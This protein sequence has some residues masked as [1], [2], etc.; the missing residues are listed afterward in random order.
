MLL[1]WEHKIPRRVIQQI[2]TSY[3]R[4][5]CWTV[6]SSKIDIGSFLKPGGAATISMGLTNGKCIDRGV[7]PWKM[8]RWSYIVLGGTSNGVS[9]LIVTGYRTG[10][11]SSIPGEK[12]A[13]SQQNTMLL[14]EKRNISPPEAFLTDLKEWIRKYRTPKMEILLSLDANE[15][16]TEQ[17]AITHFATDLGLCNINEEFMLEATHPNIANVSRSTTI[18]FC[19]SSPAVLENIAYAASTPFD[20]ETLGDHCGLLLDINLSKL[21]GANQPGEVQTARKLVLSNPQAVE[22][23][24]LTVDENFTKQNIY[25]RSHKLL[26]RVNQGQTD[27]ANIMKHY[28]ALDKEV[29]GICKKAEHGC[30]PTWSGNYEWSPKLVQ[31]I[32]QIRYWRH[33]LKQNSETVIIQKMG[34]ELNIPYTDLRY[35]DILQRVNASKK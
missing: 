23:Y 21:L 31:A 28:E 19:L 11:R 30:R 9:L 22:K 32:K 1:V 35:E 14:K 34:Q 33:R 15:N 12:T 26:R 29:L 5:S 16:W 25:Q 20:L 3:D 27:L 4:T 2:T 6:A 8:G 24:L 17:S 13:W 7:D 18:D 10:P